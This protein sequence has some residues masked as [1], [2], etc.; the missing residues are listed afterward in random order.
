M[1]LIEQFK[2][3]Q[4]MNLETFRKNGEGVK[5]PVWFAQDENT[6]RVWTST[7]S[8]KVKRIRRDGKVRV[9]PSTASGEPIGEWTDA[10]SAVLDSAEELKRT[11]DLFQKKYGLLFNMF[12][13]MGKMRGT[14]YI[15]LNVHFNSSSSHGN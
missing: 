3:K 5:T 6:L 9:V 4:Y 14:A 13:F 12:A 10:T 11:R 1:K 8:G 2:D 7:D 15:T